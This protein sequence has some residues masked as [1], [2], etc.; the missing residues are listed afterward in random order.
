MKT[1]TMSAML[2]AALPTSAPATTVGMAV[3]F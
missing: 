2:A 1:F 3:R